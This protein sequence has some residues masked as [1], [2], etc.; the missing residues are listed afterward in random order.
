MEKRKRADGQ[1]S[2]LAGELFAAAEL[3]RRGLQTSVTFGNAKA[4]DLLAYHPVTKRSFVVQVK[5]VRTKNFFLI[6]PTKI[7]P[8]HI[9]IFVLLNT[10]GKHVQ[11]YVVPGQVLYSEPEKFSKYFRTE[12]MPGIHPNVLSK[13]GYEDAW[14]VF[15]AAA[16]AS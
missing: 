7:E 9:Y 2:G 4:V 16:A 13:L 12:K 8:T 10:P 6:S 5:T 15:E 14:D 1:I 3:L 11:Y